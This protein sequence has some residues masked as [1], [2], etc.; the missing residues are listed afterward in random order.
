MLKRT[1]TAMD[2]IGHL[3]AFGDEAVKTLQVMAGM[4][5]YDSRE[6]DYAVRLCGRWDAMSE[7]IRDDWAL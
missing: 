3:L 6:R 5:P 4:T 2:D 1:D 7:R